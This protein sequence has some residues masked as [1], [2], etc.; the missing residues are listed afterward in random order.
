VAEPRVAN[1]YRLAY[2]V[3]DPWAEGSWTDGRC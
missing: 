3:S 1:D 2:R